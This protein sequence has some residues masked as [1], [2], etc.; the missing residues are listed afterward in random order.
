MM[1]EIGRGGWLSSIWVRNSDP[2]YS[3]EESKIK[4]VYTQ[5]R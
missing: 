1:K 3:E 5:N 2:V 4:W